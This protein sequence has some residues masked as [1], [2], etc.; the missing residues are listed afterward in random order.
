MTS[1]QAEEGDQVVEDGIETLEAI[2]ITGEVVK[3]S[4]KTL[5]FPIQPPPP[6]PVMVPPIFLDPHLITIEKTLPPAHQ[7]ILDSTSHTRKMRTPAKPVNTPHPPYP[8]RA[9]EQGWEGK[10]ILRLDISSK[11]SVEQSSVQKSSGYPLLDS[12][13]IQAIRAWTFEPAKNGEFPVA[14]AVNLPINFN[15]DR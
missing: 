5:S 14:S 11:G 6:L 10:V 2:E 7:I 15:L 9:R 3:Q 1:S 4:T 13:A 8:R 12:S